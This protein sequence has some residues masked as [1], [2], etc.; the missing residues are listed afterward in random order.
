MPVYVLLS[1][2]T[3]QVTGILPVF[4]EKQFTITSYV[5]AGALAL[6]AGVVCVIRAGRHLPAPVLGLAYTSRVVENVAV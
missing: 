4:T 5:V 6:A 1:L 2:I 3:A